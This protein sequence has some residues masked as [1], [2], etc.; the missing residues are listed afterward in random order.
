[1]VKGP[2][3]NHVGS[4]YWNFTVTFSGSITTYQVALHCPVTTQDDGQIKKRVQKD[5]EWMSTAYSQCGHY[6]VIAW[7]LTVVTPVSWWC[8]YY[9]DDGMHESR[10]VLSREALISS[11]RSYV[12]P[13]PSV[14]WPPRH[15]RFNRPGALQSYHTTPHR[16]LTDSH[17]DAPLAAA[18]SACIH[19][20]MESVAESQIREYAASAA[21]AA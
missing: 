12:G 10:L 6:V 5:A 1:M 16:A 2:R 11:D 13:N 14:R 8:L 3:T 19:I 21:A 4:I 18:H 15:R 9:L 20:C 7:S 17:S